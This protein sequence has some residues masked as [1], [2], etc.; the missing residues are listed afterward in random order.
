MINIIIISIFTFI[1]TI[2]IIITIFT[3]ITT[4]FIIIVSTFIA[5]DP[6]PSLFRVTFHLHNHL[7]P[8]PLYVSLAC[9]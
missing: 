8:P 9:R 7:L 5:N 3:F 2:I 4:I 6:S 1:T